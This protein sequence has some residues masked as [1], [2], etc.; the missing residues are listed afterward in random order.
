MALA[1][2]GCASTGGA[3]SGQVYSP[4]NYVVPDYTEVDLGV[5][6]GKFSAVSMKDVDGDGY[7]EI[8]S[9]TGQDNSPLGLF[10][11]KYSG[12]AWSSQ[13]LAAKGYY[14]GLAFADISKDGTLDVVASVMDG[15]GDPVGVAYWTGSVSGPAITW[16]AQAFPFS[17]TQCNDVAVGDIEPDGDL[18]LVA[19]TTGAGLKVLV[20]GGTGSSWT[21]HTLDTGGAMN[22]GVAL[23]DLNGDSRLDVASAVH[24]GT[25][26]SVFLCSA[27][28]AVSYSSA[29]TTGLGVGQA[30]GM[31]IADVVGDSSGDLLIGVSD[32]FRI[33]RGNGCTGPESGWWQSVTIPGLGRAYQMGIGD[34]DQDGDDDIAIATEGGIGLLEKTGT[35]TFVRKTPANVPSSQDWTG[36]CL[37]DWD[38]DGDL[39]LCVSSWHGN[40]VRLY[41]SQLV[42]PEYAAP[43]AIAALACA[44]AV[45]CAAAGIARKKRR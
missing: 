30:M 41:I 12:S 22:T 43:P 14:G 20:N 2:F 33:Y 27:S 16:T 36:S 34:I 23:G 39:D 18:D 35:D 5:Q 26:C 45:F 21:T 28:G 31:G 25:G 4:G 9:G 42:V 17:G 7:G 3:A 1:A 40:G 37:S 38:G 44:A 10:V 32:G 6:S 15:Q 24:S 19:A 29:H 13:A 8:L 11:W